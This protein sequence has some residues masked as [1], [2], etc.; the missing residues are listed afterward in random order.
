MLRSQRDGKTENLTLLG[1]YFAKQVAFGKE[2]FTTGVRSTHP[3]W[4]VSGAW[5]DD[6]SRDVLLGERLAARLSAKTGDEVTLSGR[7]R[8]SQRNS[9][10]RRE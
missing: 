7:Q 2:E 6:G 10:H 1:T 9:F 4:K 8:A 3:W 5:P